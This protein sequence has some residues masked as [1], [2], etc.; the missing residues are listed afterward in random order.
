[1][2]EF[3]V[4]FVTVFVTVLVV[5]LYVAV[6]ALPLFAAVTA[7]LVWIGAFPWGK[8]VEVGGD[9]EPVLETKDL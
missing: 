4:E 7:V 6:I 9:D 1:M 2:I 8:T 3:V 5:L